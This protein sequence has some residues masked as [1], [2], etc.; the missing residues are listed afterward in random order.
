[1]RK[2]GTL[3][4]VVVCQSCLPFLLNLKRFVYWGDLPSHFEDFRDTISSNQTV[5]HGRAGECISIPKLSLERRRKHSTS[6]LLCGRGGKTSLSSVP[7][8]AAG[9]V[10]Q[11]ELLVQTHEDCVSAAES[12]FDVLS[13]LLE[14]ASEGMHDSVRLLSTADEEAA[15][16]LRVK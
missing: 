3:N 4:H 16:E 11:G 1:M 9:N 2:I 5:L 6:P 8:T 12:A 15:E 10:S 13:G 7:G 14:Q